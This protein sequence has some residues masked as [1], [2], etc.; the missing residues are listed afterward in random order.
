MRCDVP[1]A[2][3]LVLLGTCGIDREGPP[4]DAEPWVWGHL[5]SWRPMSQLARNAGVGFM[6]ETHLH[7]QGMSMCPCTH[8]RVSKGRRN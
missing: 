2:S 5:V 6:V 1:R 7:L 3:L 8:V 4:K